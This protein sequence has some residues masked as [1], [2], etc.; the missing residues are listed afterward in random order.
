LRQPEGVRSR[1]NGF[2]SAFFYPSAGYK[3][4]L[5]LTFFA[6]RETRQ[7]FGLSFSGEQCR[8]RADRLL[9]GDIAS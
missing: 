8:L 1:P 9:K 5:A 7:E 6:A 2:K 3:P 4:M